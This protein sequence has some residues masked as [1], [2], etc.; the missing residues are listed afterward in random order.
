MSR[1]HFIRE[2]SIDWDSVDRDSYVRSIPALQSLPLVFTS[3]V[4]FFTGENG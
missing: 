1:A 2:A 3:N 4:T